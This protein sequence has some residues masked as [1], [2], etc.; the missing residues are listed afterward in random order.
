V[1]LNGL[2]GRLL[3]VDLSTG[4]VTTYDVPPE[5]YRRFIGGRGLAAWILWRELGSRWQGVDP[6]GPE[7]LLL[8]LTG[9]LTGYY[10]GI[11]MVVSGK[12]PQSNGVVGS[13][14]SSEVAVQLKAAGYDGI[15]I[16]G[17]ADSPVYLY[18]SDDSVELRDASKLWGLRGTELLARLR[19]ELKQDQREG[20]RPSPPALY[21][22][23]A[24]ENMVRTAVVMSN[25][26]HAAG[27]G[28]YGAVMGSKKLKAVVVQGS[29]PLP[30]VADP[31]GF[32]KL[33]RELVAKLSKRH[34]LRY[35]GTASGLY[36]H[37]YETSSEPVRNWQEEW[38]DEKEFSVRALEAG[39]WRKRFWADWGCPLACMKVSVV[40]KGGRA[41]VTDAPDYEMGAYLGANLGVFNV[42][43][44]AVLSAVADDLGLCGIQT[45]NV[46][47]FAVELCEKGVLSKEDVGYEL[48]WGDADAMKRLLEDIAYRRGIGDVL[49]EGTYRAALRIAKMKGLEPSEVLR[50]AVQVKGIGVGAHGIRSK[51]DYPQPI[52]Y[53]ASVQGGDHTSVAGLPADSTE[54]ESWA[55]LLD[56]LVACMFLETDEDTM[57]S[58]LNAVTGWDVAREEVYREIG[59]RILTLQRLLLLLGGPD[60]YWD[61]R[62]H[63]DNP[64]RF[65]EPLPS[66]PYKGAKADREEVKRM[67]REYYK[68]LGW[69]ELGIPTEETLR[70]LGLEDAVGA[71]KAVRRRLGLE[72]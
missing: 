34:G 71:V 58:Y 32:A 68:A 1:S 20:A 9:P 12:S 42:K 38:H 63:D 60:V 28:G 46:A 67:K 14:L 5:V 15:I 17:R 6:L 25:Y 31:E 48:R 69:D 55:A 29:G 41:Y 52:A 24:G 61:P 10:P 16:R 70:S 39:V 3:D 53:A 21:I 47:G 54:S 7:N 8:L 30:D 65:Y 49:A 23:P 33:R 11:K 4:R 44:A 72:P 50:Y 19:E 26:A 35:W 59:P 56:S 66:G 2:W 18:V 40:E 37:G 27:Y 57:L 13:T 45:G 36:Y 51:R 62:I 64:P 22:G 43:E